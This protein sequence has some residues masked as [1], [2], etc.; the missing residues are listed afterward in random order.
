M[1][2]SNLRGQRLHVMSALQR[3]GEREA[4]IKAAAKQAAVNNVGGP[5][6]DTPA[7]PAKK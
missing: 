4:E 3:R 1:D 5:T 2:A 6:V 7:S